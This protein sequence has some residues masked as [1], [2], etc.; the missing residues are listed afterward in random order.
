MLMLTVLMSGVTEIPDIGV[1]R[2]V[3]ERGYE[4]V[5]LFYKIIS[6][7][8]YDNGFLYEQFRLIYSLTGFLLIYLAIKRIV[9][10]STRIWVLC[11]YLLYP[12]IE[13]VPQARNFLAMSLLTMEQSYFHRKINGV[14]LNILFYC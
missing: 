9:P 5:E 7:L 10:D 3:F 13:D 4:N 6:N 1:Y 8:F 14:Q 2:L 12:F 11:L